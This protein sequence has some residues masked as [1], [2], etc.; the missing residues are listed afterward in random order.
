M[1]CE[2]FT[3]L[4]S[5]F[6]IIHFDW[7]FFH[8]QHVHTGLTVHRVWDK[9]L[10]CTSCQSMLTVN[11]KAVKNF[12]HFAFEI[13]NMCNLSRIHFGII[14]RVQFTMNFEHHSIRSGIYIIKVLK[15][16][17]L[18]TKR[19]WFTNLQG[20]L[21]NILFKIV[22]DFGKNIE[23]VKFFWIF[24]MNICSYVNKKN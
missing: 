19:I 20:N 23:K 18:L 17:C 3:H 11:T 6:R 13:Q 12:T 1:W 21:N 15:I 2:I 8:N 14:Q 16:Q 9:S 7:E 5:Y 24:N 22:S 10:I 4:Y